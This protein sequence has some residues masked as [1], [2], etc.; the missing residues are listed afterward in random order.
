MITDFRVV[1]VKPKSIV[2]KSYF[3]LLPSLR[4]L[5][6]TDKLVSWDRLAG[7]SQETELLPDRFPLVFYIPVP[8]EAF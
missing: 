7:R 8:D 2:L 5:L 4:Q 3:K 6:L 1:H